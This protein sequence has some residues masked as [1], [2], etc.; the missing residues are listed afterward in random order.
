MR[1]PLRKPIAWEGVT[2]EALEL[3]LDALTGRDL[4]KVSR[5]LRV[6]GEHVLHPE[7]DDRYIVA[8]AARAAK[9]PV[10]LLHELPARD[11]VRVKTEVQGFLLGSDS[12]ASPSES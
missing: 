8:V 6:A 2:H 12:D 3:D 7:T 4:M 5:E 10:E 11:F 9:V 1:I